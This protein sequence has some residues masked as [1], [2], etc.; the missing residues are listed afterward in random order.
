MENEI[1]RPMFNVEEVKEASA[2]LIELLKKKGCPH[3]TAIVSTD[4]IKIVSD[5]IGVSL[6]PEY[7][8]YKKIN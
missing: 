2:P 7:P 8:S 3:T 6:I 5:E 1:K 4:Y